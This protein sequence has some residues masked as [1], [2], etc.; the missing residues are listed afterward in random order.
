MNK[1][2]VLPA[3]VLL[4]HGSPDPEWRGPIE[5]ARDRM[6]ELD[7]RREIC[8][9]YLAHCSPSLEAVANKLVNAGHTQIHVVATFLSAGGEHLKTDVPIAVTALRSQHPT[10]K[11]QLV[12]GALGAE[13]E[14]TEALARAALRRVLNG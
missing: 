2:P 13:P 12:A 9:A 8:D 4:A 1:G 6:R 11:I 3:I 14:V 5:A 10:V 7:P